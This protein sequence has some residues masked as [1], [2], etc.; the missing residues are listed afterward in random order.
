M[1]DV[2]SERKTGD[3]REIQSLVEVEDGGVVVYL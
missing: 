1:T 3:G 2:I